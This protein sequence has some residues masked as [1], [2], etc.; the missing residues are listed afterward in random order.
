MI[1]TPKN[2]S[3]QVELYANEIFHS[4]NKDTPPH[5]KDWQISSNYVSTLFQLLDVYYKKDLP[6]AAKCFVR[7]YSEIREQSIL[8]IGVEKAA[9]ILEEFFELI[10][11]SE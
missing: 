7:K 5:F 6:D 3:L 4:Q 10:G 2:I 8:D 11:I 9:F 1:L